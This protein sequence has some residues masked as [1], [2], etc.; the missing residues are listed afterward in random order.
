MRVGG[1]GALLVEGQV[2]Q[3]VPVQHKEVWARGFLEVVGRVVEASSAQE[4]DIALMWLLFLPQAVLRQSKRGGRSGRGLVARRFNALATGQWGQLVQWWEEDRADA[5]RRDEGSQGAQARVVQRSQAEVEAALAGVVERLAGKGQVGKAMRRLRSY[6]VADLQSVLDRLREKY[7]PRGRELPPAAEGEGGMQCVDQLEG[8]WH[9]LLCLP[10][11]VAPGSGGLRNEFLVAVAECVAQE[12]GGVDETKAEVLPNFGLLYLHGALP[13]WFYKVWLTVQTVPLYKD[14]EQSGIRPVGMRNPLLKALHSEVLV[15]VAAEAKAVLEPIQLGLAKHC[16]EKLV[17]AVRSLLEVAQA[18]GRPGWGGVKLDLKNAFNAVF[19]ARVLAALQAEPSLRHLVPLVRAL[20]EGG[21]GLEAGGV[22]WGESSEGVAQGDPLSMLLFCVGIH[23]DLV[24]LQAQLEECGGMVRAGADDVYVVGPLE[25]V[26]PKVLEMAAKLKDGA[27]LELE[28]S[29]TLVLT[30]DGVEHP[31][32]AAV[33]LPQAG[34]EVGGVFESGFVCHGVPVGS[35]AF[36]RAALQEKVDELKEVHRQA[37]QVLGR[38]SRQALWSGLKGSLAVQFDHLLKAVYPPLVM[39]AARE[40]DAS[41]WG[42]LGTAAGQEVPRGEAGFQVRQE[43]EVAWCWEEFVVRLPVKEG[44]LGLRSL[45]E[46]ARACFASTVMA[47]VPSF[48][49]EGVCPQLG[50]VVGSCEGAADSSGRW[51]ELVDSGCRLGCEFRA[52]WEGVVGEVAAATRALGKEAPA[53]AAVEVQ[54]AGLGL[55]EQGGTVQGDLQKAREEVR[56]EFFRWA[57]REHPRQ[58]AR[59]VWSWWERDKLSSQWAL[60]LPGGATRLESCEFQEVVAQHLCLQSP[61]CAARVGQV[62]GK[63]V[64]D[65]YGD[66]LGSER[67]PGDGLRERHDA[68]KR[69]LAQLA[70]WAGVW[71]QVEVFGEFAHLIPQEGLSR[72]EPGRKRQGLVPDF[73]L[74]YRCASEEQTVLAELKTLSCCPSRYPTQ[75]GRQVGL[76]DKEDDKGRAVERRAAGLQ[77]EYLRKAR[78][79][80]SLTVQ[81]RE[82]GALGPVETA[83]GSFNLLGFVFG[84]FGE[85]SQDVHKFVDVLAEGRCGVLQGGQRGRKGYRER[86]GEKSVQVGFLRRVLSVEAVRARARL[87]LDRLHLVGEGAKQAQQRRSFLDQQ[88]SKFDREL[89]RERLR[90]RGGLGGWRTGLLGSS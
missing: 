43:V 59:Q 5:E 90:S 73:K 83:V 39:E 24:W 28:L 47:V 60:A 46:K 68:L 2:L 4:L 87:V 61:G 37:Q 3:E 50:A 29:K 62:V 78:R 10:E 23:E 22:L 1:W 64:L 12:R 14:A 34:K 69:K 11:E 70:R 52:A 41:L 85:A 20:F 74:R 53:W 19:Q 58:E 76:G 71:V 57:L 31:A 54:S 32:A 33:G 44:G 38:S 82:E 45:E 42:V 15:S 77:S 56:L 89:Q 55:P 18:E 51:R 36:V 66:K 63:S 75:A 72:L 80:D 30:L 8:L 65:R 81:D 21:C 7:P 17:F 84:A 16:S 35:D 6:G 49:E 25:V 9:R 67:L 27:G 48:V 86:S 79:V 40:L 26:V 13:P 88:S